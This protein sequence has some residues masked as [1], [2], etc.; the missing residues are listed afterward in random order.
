MNDGLNRK[1]TAIKP[2]VVEKAVTLK[3]SAQ[4]SQSFCRPV[5]GPLL[6]RTPKVGHKLEYLSFPRNLLRKSK[7]TV[8]Y[9]R[10]SFGA[11]DVCGVP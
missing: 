11:N 6:N 9:F 4:A 5:C 3:I 1:S 10:R 2:N 7:L 8:G